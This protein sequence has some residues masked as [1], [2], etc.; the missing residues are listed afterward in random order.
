MF[1]VSN[2]IVGFLNCLSLLL[3]LGA[4]A[5]SLYFYVHGHSQCEKALQNPLLITG[6]ILLVVSLLG[7]IG[8]CCR[9]NTL[10]FVYLMIMFCLMI[11]LLGFTVFTFLVTND[12]VGKTVSNKGVSKIR[13]WDF[14]NWL[15][16]H[17]VNGKNWDNIKSCLRKSEICRTSDFY[18]KN[19]SPIQVI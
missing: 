11:G 1:R 7:L 3:G 19:F 2:F 17:F 18:Q 6:T 14:A 5:M 13:T 8:S 12:G 15:E 9:L 10:L 4:I 16:L